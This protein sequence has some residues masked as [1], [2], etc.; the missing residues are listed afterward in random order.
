MTIENSQK[1]KKYV[2]TKMVAPD[3]ISDLSSPQWKE[4]RVC[5]FDTLDQCAEYIVTNDEYWYNCRYGKTLFNTELCDLIKK[6]KK[7]RSKTESLKS[8]FS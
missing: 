4:I 8:D 5:R 1:F 2:V 7:M 6:L 3:C